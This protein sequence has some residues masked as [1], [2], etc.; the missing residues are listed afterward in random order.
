MMETSENLLC[1]DRSALESYFVSMGE[2]PFR[3]R[4]LLQWIYQRDVLSFSGMTDLSKPLRTRLDSEA[5]LIL[6]EIVSQRTSTDG[7]VKWLIRLRDGNCIETVYIPEPDRGTLCI[8]SQVGCSLNCTFCAT[9][10]QGYNRNLDAGEIIS[11]VLLASR[12]LKNDERLRALRPDRALERPVTNVVLMGMGEPLLNLDNVVAAMRLMMDDLSFGLSW[13]RVTLSTAG[14]VPGI[15]ALAKLCR[16]AL[17]VSL[18]APNDEL[19]TRLVPLNRK[20]PIRM[21][22]D[23]CRRYSN[24][25]NRIR[26]TFEYVMLEDVNDDIGHARELAGLLQD[27]ACKVNLIPFNPYPG[28][29]YKRS[30]PDRI[31]RF[32]E[33]LRRKDVFVVTRRTR[34]EDIEAACGQLAGDFSD[35]TRRSLRMSRPQSELS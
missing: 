2:K 19:R 3:A 9:A 7:T 17:A 33:E 30:G 24:A 5:C 15:D 16:V 13:R 12:A 1:L 27:I 4:Q 34:G 29:L 10:R 22:L 14:H 32:S 25:G 26:V 35:R 11:Q 18:H 6:P 21:L 23:S 8:S 31:A 20:Y 28:I